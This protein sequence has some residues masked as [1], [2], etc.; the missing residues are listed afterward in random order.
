MK[1]LAPKLAAKAFIYFDPPYYTK[2]QDLYM[3]HYA[4]EDHARVARTV[5]ALPKKVKWMVSYDH[6]PAIAKLYNEAS[7]LIEI[8]DIGGQVADVLYLDYGYENM[9][10]TDRETGTV[11]NE[12]LQ[13]HFYN[14][15]NYK[16][17]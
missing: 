16:G 2:G 17:Q 6:H 4:E 8:N 5:A 1:R 15:C 9:L 3:N 11:N 10:F 7:I 13:W 12:G 14:N